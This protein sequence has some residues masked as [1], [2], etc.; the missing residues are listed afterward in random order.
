M[1]FF[2]ADHIM[3]KGAEH[4]G[5]K[6]KSVD[7]PQAPKN[8]D[9]GALLGEFARILHLGGQN[10]QQQQQKVHEEFG[11]PQFTDGPQGPLKG[12]VLR[13][14]IAADELMEL[15]LPGQSNQKKADAPHT[16]AG[17]GHSKGGANRDRV[18]RDLVE[19]DQLMELKIP[20]EN[21]DSYTGRMKGKVQRDIIEADELMELRIDGRHKER[22]VDIVPGRDGSRVYLSGEGK[23]LEV[24][25]KDGIKTHIEYGADGNPSVFERTDPTTGEH[26]KFERMKSVPGDPWKAQ[27]RISTVDE[28]GHVH[29]EKTRQMAIFAEKDGDVQIFGRKSNGSWKHFNF[30]SDGEMEEAKD[31]PPGVKHKWP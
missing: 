8:F 13:D 21:A 27:W 7:Q 20:K 14:L 5:E 23:P 25:T 18:Q 11:T 12:K 29:P 22:V 31:V 4:E 10:D 15:R 19:A 9:P 3:V 1:Q 28:K 24:V 30:T 6:R 26:Y 2:G 16:A 17:D